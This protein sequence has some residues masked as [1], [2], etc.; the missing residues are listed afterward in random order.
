MAART[1]MMSSMSATTTS[2]P[3]SRSVS[4][5]ASSLR[6]MARTRWPCSSRVAMA[7]CAVEPT[8][9][10]APVTRMVSWDMISPRPAA[11]PRG[12]STRPRKPLVSDPDLRTMVFKGESDHCRSGGT[13][14]SG[15]SAGGF[16]LGPGKSGSLIPVGD[17]HLTLAR[18]EELP[19]IGDRLPV[20]PD[21]V[22]EIEH[23]LVRPL[24][25]PAG[26]CRS[27]NCRGRS[28]KGRASR[29]GRLVA[30]GV[31]RQLRPDRV[32][33]SRRSVLPVC[34]FGRPE[35]AIGRLAERRRVLH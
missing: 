23:D 12:P 17:H 4:A 34:Q 18:F 26:R 21:V 31:R 2:A 13:S 11:Y 30:N 27:S 24:G 5:R 14:I 9:P 8:P 6:T 7:V 10:A 16:M 15:M 22:E 25:E 20:V 33:M 19:R 35:R 32:P 29:R 1:A 3:M 28:T